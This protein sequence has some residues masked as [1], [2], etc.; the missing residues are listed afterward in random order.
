MAS[1]SKKRTTMA[2]MNRERAVK[3]KQ[4]KKQA[5]REEKKAIREAEARGEDIFG[6]PLGEIILDP[7]TGEPMLDPDTGKP[8]RKP[9]PVVVADEAEP[10]D[11]EPGPAG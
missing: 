9:P 10:G 11:E 8:L 2:K 6:A 7:A 5:R 1:S 3:E 4:A